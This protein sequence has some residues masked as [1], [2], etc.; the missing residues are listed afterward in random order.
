MQQ[1]SPKEAVVSFLITQRSN[2]RHE[3]FFIIMLIENKA[4]EL[5]IKRV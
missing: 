1:R 3:D 2:Y 5:N 4:Y